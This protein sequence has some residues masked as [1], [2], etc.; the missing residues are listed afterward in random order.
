MPVMNRGLDQALFLC[1]RGVFIWFLLQELLE[2]SV[3]SFPNSKISSALE[4]GGVIAALTSLFHKS[5]CAMQ[6][7]G[8]QSLSK[9]E[10]RERLSE[11]A[12]LRQGS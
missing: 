8:F 4:E 11:M 12:G 1:M 7:F 2:V 10:K 3:P 6:I 9:L 5:F